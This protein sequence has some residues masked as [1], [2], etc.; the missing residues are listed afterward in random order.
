MRVW[1]L[2]SRSMKSNLSEHAHKITKVKLREG[3][4]KLLTSS[5]D[6][7]ILFWDIVS[8]DGMGAYALGKGK[9]NCGLLL[10]DGRH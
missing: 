6:K 9:E 7:S 10:A 1:E 4:S 3:G 8:N 2:R 5:K